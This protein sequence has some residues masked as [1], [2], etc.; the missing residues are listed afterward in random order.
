MRILMLVA[1]SVATDTRVLREASA[2][3]QA[4]HSVHIIGKAVPEGYAPPPG[5]TVTSAG[6]PPLSSQRTTALGP[7][8]AF[9]R[10]FLLPRVRARGFGLWAAQASHQAASLQFDAVHAHDFT[11]LEAGAALAE[12]RAVPLVYDSHELWS[13]R[14]R[15]YR[16]TPLQDLRDRATEQRLGASA[17]AVITVG[18][19]VAQALR[20]RYG[21]QHVHVVRNTFPLNSD[22]SATVGAAEESATQSIAESQFS[23]TTLANHPADAALASAGSAGEHAPMPQPKGLVYAGRVDAHRELETVI[24]AAHMLDLLVTLIGPADDGWLARHRDA[25]QAA[26]VAVRP[27][28]PVDGVTALLREQGLALITHTDTF[29]SYRLAMPNKLFHAVHAGV[30]MVASDAPAVK[31]IVD[32]YRLGQTYRIG[33]P[34]DLARAVREVVTNY[35]GYLANIAAA[36]PE[37][38]WES[39]ARTLMRVYDDI[40]RAAG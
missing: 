8:R 38:S 9:L 22:G 18:D 27:A 3:V 4:G 35:P 11:A 10:W 24:A 39:D 14:Q 7:M 36:A 34:A 30:P 16:P 13:G 19:G 31:E 5:I 37:L 26:G 1:T 33:D 28:L 2:L 29:E 21:W 12:Q 20:Q 15:Q 32:R 25:L 23:R 40:A 17:A 6:R